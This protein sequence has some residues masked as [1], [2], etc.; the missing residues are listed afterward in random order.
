MDINPVKTLSCLGLVESN[1]ATSLLARISLSESEE[2]GV[3]KW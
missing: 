2:I 1:K 3:Q